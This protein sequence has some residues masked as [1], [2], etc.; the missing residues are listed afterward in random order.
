MD[1]VVIGGYYGKGKRCGTYGGYLLACYNETDE[2]YQSICKIGTGF[3][4]NDLLTQFELFKSEIIEGP[5]ESYE[6]SDTPNIKPDVWFDAK[7]VFEVKAADFS[8]S[9]VHKAAM[10]LVEDG[11]GISLRFPRFVKIRDDKGATDA[12][13]C[14]QVKEM[15]LSQVINVASKSEPGVDDDFE[16]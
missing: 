12:T 1:L 14:V 10:G 8:L 4:D 9:P 16:F 15:Y 13:G 7:V 11:R 6:Y 2:T 3:S 5:M